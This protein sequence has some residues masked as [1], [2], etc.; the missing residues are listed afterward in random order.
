MINYTTGNILQAKT[1]AIVNTVNLEGYMGKGIAYQFKK[2][3]PDN[4]TAYVKACRSEQIGIGKIFV[5]KDQD[6]Y[7]F[8]FPTKD[9]WRKKSQYE[10]VEKGMTSLVENVRKFNIS[11]ISIPPLGC[12]NGGLDWQKVKQIV[13]DKLKAISDQITIQIYAPSQYYSSKIKQA[14]KLNASHIVLMNLKIKMKKFNKTRL[15]KSAY[16]INLFSGSNYFKLNEH[17]FGPYSHSI[18]ILCRDIKEYQEFYKLSTEKAIPQLHSNII[19]KSVN[20]KLERFKTPIIKTSQLLNSINSDK[21]VEIIST[22]LWII[23]KNPDITQ[24]NLISE[25]NRWP[26]ES[27]ERFNN[28][29]LIEITNKMIK[30]GLINKSLLGFE[31]NRSYFRDSP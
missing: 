26:I 31:I 17:K 10:Y 23:E 29:E 30:M 8:N 28:E 25:F 20:E 24:D 18:E 16:F 9:R 11:S 2:E 5:Y 12:G 4:N 13:E 7:I 27:I 14:P 15:Q 1:Q 19:S 6:K 22:L 3:F 21:E